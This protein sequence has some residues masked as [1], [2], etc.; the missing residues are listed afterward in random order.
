MSL[1]CAVSHART[2]GHVSRRNT[3]ADVA[4]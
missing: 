2:A 1:R 4:R 3:A